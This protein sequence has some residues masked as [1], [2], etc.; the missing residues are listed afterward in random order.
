MTDSAG[1]AVAHLV[2]P[3]GCSDVAEVVGAVGSVV[4][5]AQQDLGCPPGLLP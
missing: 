2:A 4:D 3:A 5:R 1:A